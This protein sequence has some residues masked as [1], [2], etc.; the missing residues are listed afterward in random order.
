MNNYIIVTD[1]GCDLDAVWREKFGIE[2]VP[3]HFIVDGKDYEADLDWKKISAPDFYNLMRDG[4]RIYTA[5]VN[6]ATY[7]KSFAEYLEKGYDILSVS[8]SSGLSASIQASCVA[9]D[10]LLK[11]YPE[12]KIICVDS[13]R[14]CHALGILVIAAAELR[15][16]GKTIE[17]T[18]AWLEE[19]KLTSNMEGTADK[20][21][22][23]RQAGRV[24]AASSF[25]GGLLNI[26]PIVMA[27]A[28]GRNFAV[29]KV[30]GRKT[31]IQRIAERLKERYIEVPYQKVFISHAD[32]LEE[33]EELKK[34][35][36][37]QLNREIEVYIGYVGPCVGATV[38][39]GMLSA[40]FFG[41]KVDLNLG[42]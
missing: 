6:V 33:A 19:N 5:Q 41:K 17:D 10:E 36:F 2:Y 40:H 34:A 32:C 1:S 30:K 20:L 7:K 29:E 4:K 14:A 39:P 27:D 13:L 16:Q 23:L 35:I 18:A 21:V 24:S 22:Y 31:S 37:E 11:D 28:K 9:R 15:A 26:K 38:G 42:E 3:M 25:F 12:A 8:T